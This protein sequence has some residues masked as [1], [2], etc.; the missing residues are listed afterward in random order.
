M[1]IV[2]IVYEEFVKSLEKSVA[3][4]YIFLVVKLQDFLILLLYYLMK[5]TNLFAVASIASIVFLSGCT[6]SSD[7]GQN[8]KL[9]EC[10]TEQGA[11]MYGTNRCSHCQA[12]K[13]LF[14]YE[15]F[16]KINFVDCDK[17]KN[18]CNLAGVSGYP[19]WKF[20]DGSTLVGEQTFEALSQAA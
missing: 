1:V 9:A 15:A 12:Q 13:D 4:L 6:S 7:T 10:L 16:T 14:G 5:F 11:T 8:T 2:V 19:T 20:A 17:E 3:Y 18:V